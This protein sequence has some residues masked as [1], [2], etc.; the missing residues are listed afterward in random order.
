MF[1]DPGPGFLRDYARTHDLA[2]PRRLGDATALVAHLGGYRDRKHNPDPG[3]QTMW[4][5]HNRLLAA[6]PVPRS[7]TKS[8]MMSASRP[9]GDMH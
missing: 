3:N 9:A 4:T 8:A 2:E 6:E 7:A 5:G 1:T